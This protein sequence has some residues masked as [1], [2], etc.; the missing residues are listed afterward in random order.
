MQHLPDLSTAKKIGF[1]VPSSNTALEP[2]TS[3]ILASISN[4][5]PQSPAV[6][7]LYTR[8]PVNTVGTSTADAVQFSVETLVKAAKLLADAQGDAILWN[9]TSGMWTGGTAND[10][11]QLANAMEKATGVKCSTTTLAT[12][13]ALKT[14]HEGVG[15]ATPYDDALTKRVSE[16]FK[17]EGFD[18]RSCARLDETPQGNLM[19]AKS[20]LDDI[21]EVIKRACGDSVSS[22]VVACTNWPTAGIVHKIEGETGKVIVDSVTVTAWQALRM[23]GCKEGIEGWGKLIAVL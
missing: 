6:I 9:G 22:V 5:H 2:I 1:I 16:F 21:A 19:I 18:V 4:R 20:R 17:S 15:I 13:E 3:T 23:V 14:L 12:L 7:P 10:E 8:I 11:R